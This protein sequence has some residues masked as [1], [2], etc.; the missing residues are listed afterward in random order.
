MD[1]KLQMDHEAMS[2]LANEVKNLAV[3]VQ[4]AQGYA[5]DN[6]LKQEHFGG[7]YVAPMAYQ[8]LNTTIQQL[9][10]SVGK[11]HAFLNEAAA[12]LEQ[13]SRMTNATDVDNAWGLTKAGGDK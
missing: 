12:K 6:D 9:A 13:S 5:A 11:A 7:H 3:A 10:A 2:A 8:S 4:V 1:G